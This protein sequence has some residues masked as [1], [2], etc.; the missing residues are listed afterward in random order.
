M[1][2]ATAESYNFGGTVPQDGSPELGA[3]GSDKRVGI[4]TQPSW[5]VAFSKIDHNDAIRRGKFIRESLLC[6]NVPAIDITM[7]S[8]LDLSEDKT[9][10]ESLEQHRSDPSCAGCHSM[11]DPLGLAFAGFDHLGREREMEAGRPVDAA[12]ELAGAG[13]QDGPFD[14]VSD[15]MSKLAASE[16][17]RQ[18]FVVHAYEYFRGTIRDKADG[19]ALQ[20]AD[21]ALNAANGDIAA[22]ISAFFASDGFLIRASL[23]GQ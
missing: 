14:G 11:M 5:L 22:L 18:C 9:M 15:L 2:A 3:F 21:D 8:P 6:G 17:A 7:V 23:E 16:T 4:M 12:G 20:E 10:R 13:S 19:C 1:R